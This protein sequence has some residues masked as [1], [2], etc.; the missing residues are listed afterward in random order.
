[1]TLRA[2]EMSRRDKSD[3]FRMKD[4]TLSQWQSDEENSQPTE[5]QWYTKPRRSVVSSTPRQVTI[6]TYLNTLK[7]IQSSDKGKNDKKSEAVNQI[8][9]EEKKH[10]VIF[11]LLFIKKIIQFKK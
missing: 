4:F 7:K 11:E 3:E 1:M 9:K 5:D 10:K 6:G 2:D 8:K